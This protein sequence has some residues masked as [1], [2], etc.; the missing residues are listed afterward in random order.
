MFYYMFVISYISVMG[1]NGKIKHFPTVTV[2]LSFSVPS[3]ELSSLIKMI[4]TAPSK[5]F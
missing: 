1:T 4:F 3:G 5:F 2:K